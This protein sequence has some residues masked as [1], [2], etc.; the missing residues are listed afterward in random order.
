MRNLDFRV[1]SHSTKRFLKIDDRLYKNGNKFYVGLEFFGGDDIRIEYYW[2]DNSDEIF[3][4]NPDESKFAINQYTGL[5]DRNNKEIFEGDII[6]LENFIYLVAHDDENAC[7]MLQTMRRGELKNDKNFN[8]NSAS[9]C[10]V[11]GNF[12]QNED[13]LK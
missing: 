12:Y 13:L 9:V 8:G 6:E 7:Y 10:K 4:E 1:F 3:T 2:N 11:I 5:K